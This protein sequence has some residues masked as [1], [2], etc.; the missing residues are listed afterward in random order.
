M[1]SMTGLAINELYINKSVNKEICINLL[2]TYTV[3]HTYVPKRKYVLPTFLTYAPNTFKFL[4]Y[5]IVVKKKV[6]K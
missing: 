4:K 5:F 6:F 2:Y 3:Q 1:H